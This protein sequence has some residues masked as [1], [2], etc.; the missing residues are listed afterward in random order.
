MEA[1]S[2]P[3]SINQTDSAYVTK[4]GTQVTAGESGG[5]DKLM[6]GAV[7]NYYLAFPHVS[8]GGKLVVDMLNMQ[9]LSGAS[10]TIP[11]NLTV[12]SRSAMGERVVPARRRPSPPGRRGRRARR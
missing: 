5:P 3:L 2:H 12:A 11:T 4:R 7:G 10:V 6:A 9:G 1:G 8:V